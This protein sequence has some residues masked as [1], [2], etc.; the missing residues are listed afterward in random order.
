VWVTILAF[1]TFWIFLFFWQRLRSLIF[2]SSPVLFVD[3]FC[4]DQVDEKRKA[5]A[6][7]SIAGFLCHSSRLVICWTP[8]YFTRLWTLYEIASWMHLDKP[9]E[10]VIFVP[11]SQPI[12]LLGAT[13]FLTCL[14][15]IKFLVQMLS[16]SCCDT[17]N[18][19]LSFGAAGGITV[20]MQHH[21]RELDII[22]EQLRNFSVSKAQCFCCTHCHIRPDSGK[23]MSCDRQLVYRTLER[24]YREEVS[25]E[26]GIQYSA[27]QVFDRRV[28]TEFS[29]RIFSI[30]G[31]GIRYRQILTAV[32]PVWWQSCDILAGLTAA[33]C[34]AEV[35]SRIIL[36]SVVLGTLVIPA[37][38]IVVFRMIPFIQQYSGWTGTILIPVCVLASILLCL[39]LYAPLVVLNSNVEEHWPVLSFSLALVLLN[40]WLFYT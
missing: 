23:R 20:V 11:V 25:D 10:S 33:G 9:S 37:I 18:T 39:V 26:N 36:E 19:L 27:L 16:Q 8:T 4:V 22:R 15:W 3:K 35:A 17:L 7:Q 13:V 40:Y 12:V 34:D 21:I 6:I 31:Q 28:Q 30:V 5:A 38:I 2:L 29:S 14:Y 32:L 1:L 24:W